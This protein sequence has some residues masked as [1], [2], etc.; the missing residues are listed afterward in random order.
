MSKEV[1]IHQSVEEFLK[2]SSID[3]NYNIKQI[4]EKENEWKKRNAI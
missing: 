3:I 2:D 1:L 4:I